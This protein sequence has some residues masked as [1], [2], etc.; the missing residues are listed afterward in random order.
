MKE[1]MSTALVERDCLSWGLDLSDPHRAE[2]SRCH[3]T[4]L[5]PWMEPR[6]LC[7]SCDRYYCDM[8]D[9]DGSEE[10]VYWAEAVL[11]CSS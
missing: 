11:C 1:R 6:R 3:L 4:D 7:L 8:M 10:G 2:L 9:D 5:F